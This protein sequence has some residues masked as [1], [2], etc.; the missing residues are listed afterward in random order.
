[1]SYQKIL[2]Q[3]I[4]I[5][6]NMVQLGDYIQII[7]AIIYATSLGL[8]IFQISA[9]RK[10][11]LIQNMQQTYATTTQNL[12]NNFHNKEYLEMTMESPVVSQYY[13]LVDSPQQYY[14]I[15]QNFDNIELIFNLYKNK[16]IDM[17]L[18]M[19]WKATAESMMT[20][21]KFKKVWNKTKFSRSNEFKEFIDSCIR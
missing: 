15:I 10:S 7:S 16:M 12:Y 8:T 5:E 14:I 20:I 17:R 3:H 18:W 9:M 1:M 19:R 4:P 11:M 21:P 6:S 13:S 2:Y